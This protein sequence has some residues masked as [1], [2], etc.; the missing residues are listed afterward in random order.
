MI[1]EEIINNLYK[2]NTIA[3]WAK[4]QLRILSETLEDRVT[5]NIKSPLSQEWILEEIKRIENGLKTAASYE[6]VQA[7]KEK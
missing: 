1:K 5:G 6:S 2:V 4:N 3:G 7:A